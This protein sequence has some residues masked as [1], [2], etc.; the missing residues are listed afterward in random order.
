VVLIQ[1]IIVNNKCKCNRTKFKKILKN[2]NVEMIK[3]RSKSKRGFAETKSTWHN[4]KYHRDFSSQY[5]SFHWRNYLQTSCWNISSRIFTGLGSSFSVTMYSFT[6]R[7]HLYDHYSSHKT[8][9][10][11]TTCWAWLSNISDYIDC[12]LSQLLKIYV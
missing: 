5:S 11:G 6:I 8:P 12:F 1:N 2:Q 3:E 4:G 7:T 10:L 9:S